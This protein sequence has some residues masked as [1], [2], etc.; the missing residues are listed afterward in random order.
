[1]SF[2]Q[3]KAGRPDIRVFHLGGMR[4]AGRAFLHPIEW[5]LSVSLVTIAALVVCALCS[6]S[7]EPTSRVQTGAS[8]VNQGLLPPGD[9]V[10]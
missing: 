2:F 5:R 7:I 1:M 9:L 4:L 3:P 8:L 6:A 10:T